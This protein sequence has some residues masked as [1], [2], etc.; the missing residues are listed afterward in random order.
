MV[1]PDNDGLAATV[2]ALVEQSYAVLPHIAMPQVRLELK[3]RA[4]EAARELDN[5]ARS[6][7][8]TATT[9]GEMP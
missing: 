2:A 8:A 1:S 4:D 6:S 9:T 3:E 5:R 7:P